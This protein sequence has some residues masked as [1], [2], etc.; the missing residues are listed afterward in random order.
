MLNLKKYCIIPA[1]NEAKTIVKVIRSV[2]P[3]FNKVIVV[4][5]ASS[6]QTLALAKKE[7]IIV[8]NHIINRDQGAALETGN[9][10]A[11]DHGAELIV[12]FDAD[13]QFLAKEINDVM[14]PIIS[15]EADI[16]FGSRFL[17][18]K[19]NMP[20]FKKNIIMAL[21]RLINKIFLG[22]NL[23]DPQSGFRALSR[24]AA[25]KI[26]I[27]NDGKAHCSEIMHKAVKY[28]LR[29]KEVPITVIYYNFGQ[30]FSGGIDILKELFLSR[31]IN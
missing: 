6:D 8:L 21:A 10:Y 23:T 19:S 4:N 5:D 26:I 28:N 22:V 3:F 1:Y 9:Q 31:L 30:R 13:G 25:K 17:A 2:K 11:L 16:V 27:E 20:W 15:G 29:I 7:D 14:T 24:M 12:H 18:K